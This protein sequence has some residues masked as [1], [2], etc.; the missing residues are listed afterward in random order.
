MDIRNLTELQKTNRML[1]FTVK[2][3]DEITGSIERIDSTAKT[4]TIR[5]DG[6]RIIV[7]EA[8]DITRVKPVLIK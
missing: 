4:V 1:V 2:G 8:A 5:T 3:I 6:S 7:I